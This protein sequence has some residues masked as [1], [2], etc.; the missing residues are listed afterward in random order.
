MLLSPNFVS[1]FFFASVVLADRHRENY[2]QPRFVNR[3]EQSISAASDGV[4]NYWA[5]AVWQEGNVRCQ[6]HG[7]CLA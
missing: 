6:S 1:S 7:Q 4:N 3:V 5:G 2:Y